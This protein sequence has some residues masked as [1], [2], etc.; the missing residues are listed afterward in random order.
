MEADWI[1]HLTYSD[2]RQ[3]VTAV[4]LCPRA[5]TSASD[6]DRSV[7]FVSEIRANVSI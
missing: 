3:I 7:S 2:G 1:V 5:H 4:E 6:T